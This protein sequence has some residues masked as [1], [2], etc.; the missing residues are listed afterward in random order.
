MIETR[1][2]PWGYMQPSPFSMGIAEPLH[3][4]FYESLGHRPDY[5]SCPESH[6]CRETKLYKTDYWL[7]ETLFE[8]TFAVALQAQKVKC[9]DIWQKK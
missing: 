7:N 5:T 9:G 6:G 8:E 1:G 3:V 4:L 2:T